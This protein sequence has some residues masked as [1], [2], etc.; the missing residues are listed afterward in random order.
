MIGTT[1][2]ISRDKQLLEKYGIPPENKIGL[3]LVLG[4]PDVSFQRAVRR[5]LASVTYA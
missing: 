4:H 2:A 3:T 5:R 1:V